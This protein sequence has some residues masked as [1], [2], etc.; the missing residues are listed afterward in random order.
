[1]RSL[2]KDVKTRWNSTH[3]MLARCV[4]LEEPIKSLLSEDL[5]KNKIKCGTA[6][7]KISSNDWKLM[8]NVVKVLGPFKEATLELSRASACISQT[9]PTI[10]SLL[11]TLRPT[12]TET[13]I[14]V[15]NLKRRLSDNIKNRSEYIEESEIHSFA[16]LLDPRYKNCFF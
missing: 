4:E 2:V 7:V 10:T 5:W 1:M 15:K 8:K 11:H 14:G 9:I 12:N 13:D 3:D 6:Y 16:T